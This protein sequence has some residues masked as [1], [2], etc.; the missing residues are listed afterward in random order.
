[1]VIAVDVREDEETV[2]AFAQGLDS[3]L[4]LGLDTD[5]AA[6]QGWGAFAVVAAVQRR[7]GVTSGLET[8]AGLIR[9]E[10]WLAILMTLFLLSLT[11]IPPTAGFFGKY[12]VILAAVQAAQDGWTALGVLAVVAVLNAAA[13]AFYYLRVVVYMLMR[14]PKVEQPALVHG[15]L[16]WGG[17]AVASVLTIAF[18][19]YP[20]PFLDMINQ[21][22]AA[23]GG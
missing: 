1:V 9:R 7:A 16:L 10:P 17:L 22:A 11:G 19:L 20:V 4:P 8:F 15:R 12:Y 6:Q 3:T 23:I 13:A 5:G 18:G 14:E 2:L 21:A